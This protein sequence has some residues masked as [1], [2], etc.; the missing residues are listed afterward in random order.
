[1]LVWLLRHCK[2]CHL[3][4]KLQN[5]CTLTS[6]VL[7]IDRRHSDCSLQR[8]QMS[9]YIWLIQDWLLS[10]D[11]QLGWRIGDFELDQRIT[12]QS[13]DQKSLNWMVNWQVNYLNRMIH[14]L[15]RLVPGANRIPK[16]NHLLSPIYTSS[17]YW[18][19]RHLEQSPTM[20][21]TWRWHE[22]C[23]NY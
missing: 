20:W 13:T 8:R 14:I 9:P 23:M 18:R 15:T 2:L 10:P 22:R 4:S 1:M 19:S 17:Y 6:R 5:Q 12:S 21:S 3:M 7:L 16:V 11:M